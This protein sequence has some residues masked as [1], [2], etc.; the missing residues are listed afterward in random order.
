MAGIL[1]DFPIQAPPGRIFA[2]LATPEGLNHWWTLTC[3]GHPAEGE[4]YELGFGP[5]YAWR[6]VVSRCEPD[7][8]FQLE[9]AHAMPD[10]LGTRV[11][12]ELEPQGELTW[13][14]FHHTGWAEVTEHYRITAHCWALY[15]RLLRRYCE[16]GETVPYA[17]R[18][19]A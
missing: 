15:L 11:G 8:A 5:E 16:H 18:L 4:V 6:A 19:S 14:R 9:L 10:W 1:Q 3:S 2:A 17:A 13:V 12:W 7:R